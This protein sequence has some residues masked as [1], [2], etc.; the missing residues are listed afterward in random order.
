MLPQPPR[1]P[2]GFRQYGQSDVEA[3]GFIRRVQGLGFTLKEVRELLD[4]RG[5]C[6]H[7]CAPVRR[8]LERKLADVRRKLFALEKLEKELR[9][10]VRR[11]N[12]EMRKRS[13]RCPLLQ[14]TNRRNRRAPNES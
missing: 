14:E 10:A 2:G 9:L 11:C 8:R 12:K 1:T 13:A 3:L 5:N 4:L 6:L 7:P